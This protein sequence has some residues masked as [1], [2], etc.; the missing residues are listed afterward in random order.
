MMIWR[1]ATVLFFLS[2]LYL[3]ASLGSMSMSHTRDWAEINEQ[4][5]TLKQTVFFL[6][7]FSENV[8][9]G[10]ARPEVAGALRKFA[11][12]EDIITGESEISAHRVVF[13]FDVN[14]KLVGIALD[15]PVQTDIN[16]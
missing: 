16:H 3:G 11:K 9:N 7:S 12:A 14:N 15:L 1:I 6:A 13:S 10:T 4:V 5:F 2:S 8:T